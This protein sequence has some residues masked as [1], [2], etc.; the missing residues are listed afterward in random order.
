VKLGHH[1]N[2]VATKTFAT[3]WT[4]AISFVLVAELS[5]KLVSNRPLTATEMLIWACSIPGVWLGVVV[6]QWWLEFLE[7]R[8]L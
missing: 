1:L 6:L 5:G 8:G 4:I 3:V 7:E 2:I